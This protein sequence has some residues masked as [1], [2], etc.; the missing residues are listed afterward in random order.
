[1]A[2]KSSLAASLALPENEPVARVFSHSSESIALIRSTPLDGA[3]CDGVRKLFLQFPLCGKLLN[4]QR[5]SID[6]ISQVLSRMRI[7]CGNALKTDSDEPA[8]KVHK[9]KGAVDLQ[10]PEV[11][12]V[13][14]SGVVLSEGTFG[15]AILSAV[16]IKVNE[17]VYKLIVDPPLVTVLEFATVCVSGFPVVATWTGIGAPLSEFVFE[18]RIFDSV[19]NEMIDSEIGFDVYTPKSSS[20]GHFVQ[21]HCFHPKFPQFFLK[22]TSVDKVVAKEARLGNSLVDSVGLRVATFNVLAQPYI[23]TALAQDQYYTH[24]HSC[25]NQVTDW[26]RRF[27]LIMKEMT[28][29]NADIYCLQEVAGGSHEAQFGQFFSSLGHLF[30]FFGKACVANNGNPIG[31]SISLDSSK[32]EVEATHKYNLGFG[33]D[34]LLLSML[35]ESEK[36]DIVSKFGSLFF[37]SVLKGIHT[38]CGIVE[39]RDKRSGKR[40]L[41]GNTHLFFHPFGGHI[42]TL[43]AV[44]F[45]RKLH[46]MRQGNA[47]LIVCG[48]FNSRPDSGSFRVMNSGSVEP[49][50]PDWQFGRSF[51]S[52]RYTTADLGD[53]VA[54]EIQLEST[55]VLPVGPPTDGIFISH[56]LDIDHVPSQIPELTHATAAFRSTLDYIFYSRD[57]F[58]AI[59]GPG[60]GSSFPPLTNAQVDKLGGLPAGIYGSDHVLVCGDLKF[61]AGDQ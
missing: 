14:A 37:T 8:R 32:F 59:E 43:Q 40:V 48:D 5:K 4:F 47:G 38:I 10:L 26:S 28:L 53:E 9:P 49:E 6:P 11:A 36:G 16:S 42:R 18:W 21:V 3:H 12:F 51:R 56:E 33:E 25:W 27:P 30:Y 44:C 61:V 55:T 35:S 39:A 7:S 54:D 31:V 50:N 22:S 13:D 20:L 58:E 52:D 23:R 45:M 24:L 34:S 1:M 2:H 15:E 60:T 41:I 57:V 17:E 19:T 46:Q 29:A